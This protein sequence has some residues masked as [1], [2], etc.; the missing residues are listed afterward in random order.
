MFGKEGCGNISVPIK[1][2]KVIRM[3]YAHNEA[4]IF[5][6]EFTTDILQGWKGFQ[7]ADDE[8]IVGIFGDSYD[9]WTHLMKNLGFIIGKLA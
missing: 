7:L 2:V 4:S 6:L 5:K 9:N 1:D 8:V 3:K